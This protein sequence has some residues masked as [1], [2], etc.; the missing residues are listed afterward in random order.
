MFWYGWVFS[1]PPIYCLCEGNR[2]GAKIAIN[3]WMSASEKES[4][5]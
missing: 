4:E 1:I 5:C 2:N 3:E